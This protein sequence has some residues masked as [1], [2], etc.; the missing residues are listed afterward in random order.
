MKPRRR[1]RV[2]HRLAVLTVALFAMSTSQACKCKKDDPT[3]DGGGTNNGQEDMGGT[4]NGQPDMPEDDMGNNGQPDL[5]EDDMP[6]P[7]M[8][9]D[10]G[11]LGDGN[12][13]GLR[14]VGLNVMTPF[15]ATPSPDADAVYF[16]A[17]KADGT[18]AALFSVTAAGGA[19]TEVADGFV[20]PLS[21]VSSLDGATIYVADAGADA[22]TGNPRGGLIYAVTVATGDVTPIASTAGY[23]VRSLDLVDVGGTE[24]VYFT[25]IDPAFDEAGVFRFETGAAPTV[26]TVVRGAPFGD[27]SGVAAAPDGTIYVADTLL[28]TSSGIIAVTAGAASTFVEDV[29][30]GYP[31]GIALSGDGSHLLVSGLDP[32]ANSAVVYRITLA[33]KTIQEVS[34]G[35]DQ[36]S[37]SAG[38]HRAHNTDQ[39]AWANADSPG[40]VYLIGTSASP[41]N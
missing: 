6:G 19:P 33:D 17:L 4:N 36:N 35:I 8:A 38:V 5:P 2:R 39:Y 29:R 9:P 23:K 31:A 10:M 26:A 22:V 40:T 14:E 20:A 32:L 24:T 28:G 12:I 27:P 11:E 34:M 13:T 1:W 15:D 18:S 21:L 30:V 3:P 16:V 7:D 37:E 41:L 25:G